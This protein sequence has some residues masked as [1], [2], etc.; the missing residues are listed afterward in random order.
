MALSESEVLLALAIHHLL[1]PAD[2]VVFKDFCERKALVGGEQDVPRSALSILYEEQPEFHA[3]KHHVL[4]EITAFVLPACHG[5]PFV[6]GNKFLSGM[7]VLAVLVSSVP[8]LRHAYDVDCTVSHLAYAFD[9]VDAVEPTVCEEIGC[10]DTPLPGTADHSYYHLRLLFVK[11]PPSFVAC[12]VCVTLLAEQ[13]L[14]L[15]RGQAVVAF[16]TLLGMEGA[17]KRNAA[18]SVKETERKQLVAGFVPAVSM[19]KHTAQ[20]FKVTAGLLQCR[21]IH[22]VKE[23]RI[24]AGAPTPLHYAEELLGN[25]QK[26]ATPVIGWIGQ[27]TIETVLPNLCTQQPKPLGFVKAEY[28]DLK[29]TDE[30]KVKKVS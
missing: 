22:D 15:L 14:A 17:V 29:Q 11:F 2:L 20:T 7:P 8:I 13:T 28:A 24:I 26:Q 27:E 25:T 19:I 16:P 10:T 3:L 21:V 30:Q 5:L 9:E 12:A 4:P 23:W 1:I 6:H 18:L